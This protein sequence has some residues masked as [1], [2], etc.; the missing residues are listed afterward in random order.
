MLWSQKSVNVFRSEFSLSL[1]MRSESTHSWQEL[2]GGSC[3]CNTNTKLS[4]HPHTGENPYYRIHECKSTHVIYILLHPCGLAYARET[5][6]RPKRQYQ[7]NPVRQ[8]ADANFS[9]HLHLFGRLWFLL[10]EHE[11]V[12]RE[13]FWM[14]T[15][16]T[17]PYQLNYGLQTLH[18]A[19][20]HNENDT[21]WDFWSFL[22]FASMYY[23]CR[24]A[25]D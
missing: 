24:Y 23:T 18:I 22:L 25:K 16:N 13:V 21:V 14:Y 5:K 19:T 8:Y 11:L 6:C 10:G 20:N 15:L 7:H 2:H 9:S 4:T 17:T 1:N 3:C 12:Q